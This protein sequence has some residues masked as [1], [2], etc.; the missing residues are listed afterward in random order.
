MPQ[1]TITIEIDDEV[2][3]ISFS[4]DEVKANGVTFSRD[5]DRHAPT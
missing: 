2:G 3:D 4:I 1:V 5:A